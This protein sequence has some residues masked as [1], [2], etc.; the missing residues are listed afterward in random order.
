MD[1]KETPKEVVSEPTVPFTPDAVK[2]Y[3]HQAVAKWRLIRDHALEKIPAEDRDDFA[4]MAPYYIDAFQ[5]M[6]VSLFGTLVP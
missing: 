3:L 2:K 6:H 5:S 1:K 4:A